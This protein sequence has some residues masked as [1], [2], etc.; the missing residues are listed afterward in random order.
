ML[1]RTSALIGPL[2]LSLALSSGCSRERN[3]TKEKPPAAPALPALPETEGPEFRVTA[4]SFADVR[5]LRYQVKGFEKLT[6]QQKLLAYYLYEAALSGRDIAYDQHFSHN[7]AIRR[8]LEA[9]LTSYKGDKNSAAF[10]ALHAYAKR[11]WFS[12]GIHHHY[13]SKKF[14][15]EGLTREEFG[16]LV[17]GSNP[18]KLPLT[19]GQTVEQLIATLTPIIFDPKVA[20]KRVNKDV[21]ADPVKDSA[22]NFYVGLTRE[23]VQ[24]YTKQRTNPADPRPVSY[25]LNS[26]LRK[27]PDGSIEERFW[28]VG[29]MYGPALAECVKWLEKALTVAENDAQRAAIQNLIT[30]YRTG[31]L[32]DWDRYSVAW[33]QD[34]ESKVDLIHGFIETYGDALD[35]RGTYEAL[36]QI[37]DEVATKRI[38]TLSENAQWFEDN[39]PISDDFK[40]KNV[41][42]VSARVIEAVVG[43]GDTGPAMPS[44]VNLPNSSWVRKEHGSKSVTLGNILT[45]Y[46]LASRDNGVL[47]EFASGPREVQR[48]RKHGAL[49]LAL[50]VDMHEVIGHA[51]GQ[52][53]PNVPEASETLKQYAGTLEEA[54]A[55]LVALYYIL[56]AKLVDLKLMP[57][58]DVGRAA[59]DAYI[60]G[61]LAVQLARVPL[62]ENLEE[63][64]MRNRQ[65]IARWVYE[66]GLADTVIEKLD[67]NGKTYFAVRDYVKLRKLFGELLR[68]IQRIKSEGDFTAARDLVETYGVKVDPA[69]HKEV[70]ERYAKLNVAPYAGFIQPELV[71]V[72][73]GDAI[74][75]VEIVY[76]ESFTTQMLRYAEKY[77]F[78][79]T[80][81]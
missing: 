28:Y 62:G 68:E 72:M 55:D 57:S 9:I 25:G 38:R 26:Q 3:V 46:E 80:Y 16:E 44:G 37:E 54:R 31:N 76:P 51:S 63:A 70:R 30:F 48:A 10:K 39:S 7:L 71:P 4:E 65:L 66:H 17:R 20:E 47:E 60:R 75:D 78:L 56:D 19:S 23:E 79:P 50:I 73:E 21:T 52:L 6:R 41:V 81:N 18:A 24:A 61:G 45:A 27:R 13:S 74:V 35:M 49:A 15:P 2:A 32:E 8:T 12:N 34:T 40:K 64:H 69:L 29:G 5:I 33:V 43:V 14:V 67:R 22:N 58:L 36:L 53:A 59:Y 1:L 42:G 77:T 11:V